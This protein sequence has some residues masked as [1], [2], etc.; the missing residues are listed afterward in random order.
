M[1]LPSSKIEEF[2]AGTQRWMVAVR[3]VSEGVDVPRLCV[4][5][6]NLDV[7]PNVLC[8]GCWPFRSFS[9]TW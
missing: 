5:V 6:C 3:M 7:N 2:S 9:K 1:T 8:P 4:G